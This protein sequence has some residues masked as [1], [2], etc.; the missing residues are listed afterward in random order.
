MNAD[1]NR[2]PVS[3]LAY[4]RVSDRTIERVC[5]AS[6]RELLSTWFQCTEATTVPDTRRAFSGEPAASHNIK[7]SKNAGETDT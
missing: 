1:P 6:G 3:E 7:Y 4:Q 2:E 5:V